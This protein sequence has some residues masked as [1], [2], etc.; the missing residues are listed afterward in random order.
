MKQLALGAATPTPGVATPLYAAFRN[1]V[2]PFLSM[3]YT[4]APLSSRRL[5]IDLWPAKDA[6]NNALFLL[7]SALNI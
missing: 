1:S 5:T 7:S 2:Q 4:S 3:S 6:N